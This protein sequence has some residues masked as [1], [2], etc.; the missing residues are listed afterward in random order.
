VAQGNQEIVQLKLTI[1][2]DA[3][4]GVLGSFVDPRDNTTYKTV[5]INGKTW[6]GENLKYPTKES[7]CYKN[8]TGNCSKY[9]RHYTLNE[10]RLNACPK[11]WHLPTREE[12]EALLTFYPG[13]SIWELRVGGKSN[14]NVTP[15]GIT[16]RL[17]KPSSWNDDNN[18]SRVGL[19]WADVEQTPKDEHF[20]GTALYLDEKDLTVTTHL[21]N[22]HRSQAYVGANV[23]CIKD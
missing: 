20:Y 11:G 8:Q 13:S 10:A 23:R 2:R 22:Q 7:D 1:S 12:W 16:Y 15:N 19:Y 21:S 14:F 4:V 5:T 3:Q 6:M 9:G 18:L 17:R